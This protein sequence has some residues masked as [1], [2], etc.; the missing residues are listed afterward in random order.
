VDGVGKGLLAG[1]AERADVVDVDEKINHN[2]EFVGR[3]N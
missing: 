3:T 1:I 2:N